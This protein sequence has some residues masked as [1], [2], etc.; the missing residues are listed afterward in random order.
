MRKLFCLL[1]AVKHK[2]ARVRLACGAFQTQ[3]VN[4]WKQ[5]G[6]PGKFNNHWAR[7]KRVSSFDMITLL[8]LAKVGCV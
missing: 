4:E 5:P 8:R 6:A 7:F 2:R 1:D 3:I